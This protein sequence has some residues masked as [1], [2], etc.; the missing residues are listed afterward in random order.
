MTNQS[1]SVHRAPLIA[2]KKSPLNK[3]NNLKITYFKNDIEVLTFK[4]K[5]IKDLKK[6]FKSILKKNEPNKIAISFRNGK[7]EVHTETISK[8]TSA[9]LMNELNTSTP[10]TDEEFIEFIIRFSEWCES[11]I[12]FI[13]VTKVYR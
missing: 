4:P 1:T 2:K 9:E 7:K 8:P 6:A 10:F 13:H 11:N 5:S 12:S 3:A